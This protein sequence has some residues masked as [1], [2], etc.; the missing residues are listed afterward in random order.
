MAIVR[1][2]TIC[3]LN[4]CS[5]VEGWCCSY[6]SMHHTN[7]LEVPCNPCSCSILLVRIV[8]LF[9]SGQAS[10]VFF[11][12]LILFTSFPF[13]FLRFRYCLFCFGFAEIYR[14]EFF[15][16][17]CCSVWSVAAAGRS[18][19]CCS[20]HF[21]GHIHDI[22]CTCSFVRCANDC[23]FVCAVRICSFLATKLAIAS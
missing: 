4:P 15:L 12:Y 2:S 19:V 7:K 23:A 20:W 10:N 3:A 14:L 5:G 11:D 9:R 1:I 22:C 21:V 18:S 17:V 13:R 6:V 8:F 16:R